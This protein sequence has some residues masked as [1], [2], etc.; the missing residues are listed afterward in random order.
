[1]RLRPTAL[2]LLAACCLP[3]AAQEAL[4]LDQA[5]AHP[6]WIGPPVEQAWWALDGERAYYQ[7]KR[8]GSPVRQTWAV[9]VADGF[10]LARS[11]D[12]LA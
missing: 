11:S 10:F 8:E 3:A 9:P 12:C 7:L 5:M 4:T 6:D 2:A 1:M